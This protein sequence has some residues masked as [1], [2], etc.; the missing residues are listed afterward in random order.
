M[1]LRKYV[2]KRN[3]NKTPEPKPK[4]YSLK[5]K[6]HFVVQKHS[7]TSLHYDFRLEVG[8]VL[9]SW[10]VPKGMSLNP[11]EKRLAMMVEDHPLDYMKFE[12]V[13]PKGNYGAGEVIVWDFGTYVSKNF[14]TN[15]NQNKILEKQIKNGKIE[16]ILQ[17]EKLKGI[18]YLI[19][20]QD[21]RW[22]FLKGKDEFAKEEYEFDENSVLSDRIIFTKEK[23]KDK[24]PEFIKPMLASL[25]DDPFD[26]KNWLFEIKWDGYRAVAFIGEKINLYSRNKLS[27]N[28]QFPTIVK[29]LKEKFKHKAVLD[30]EIIYLNKDGT[31]DFQLL[32]NSNPNDGN[33][34]YYVF[35][36]LFLNGHD[37]R[38]KPLIERKQILKSILPQFANIRY[39]DHILKDGKTM[40]KMAKEKQ[41]EGL[42]AKEIN[43]PYAST[44]S[45]YWLK[46][47]TSLSQEAII[48]GYTQPKGSRVKIGSLVLAIN[49]NGKL[50]YVGH[51]GT[52]FTDKMLEDIFELLNKFKIETKPVDEKIPLESKITW[53][54]P[55]IICE[56][57]FS[58]WTSDGQMRHPIFKGIRSD[59]KPK[60]ISKEEPI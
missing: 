54:K 23:G 55:E 15:A 6:L 49:Q 14:P 42:I 4:K 20:S 46:I 59:K 45:K 11:E 10:A 7:A 21:N 25:I 29:S 53:L 5:K 36:L 1:S 35:D 33:I 28:Q 13:I 51:V 22:L 27:F 48:V 34:V 56:V 30:G 41:L 17:G 32:Q 43:S 9:K 2:K 31:A 8:G 52:G 18:F 26:D 58:Q 40:F 16:I 38:A 3:L 19:K 50:K 47:K 12:G 60:E 57:K 44:R 37:L 24:V 39:S